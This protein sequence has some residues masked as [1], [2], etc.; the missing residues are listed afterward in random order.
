MNLPV[1]NPAGQLAL[2]DACA[3]P[4]DG[5]QRDEKLAPSAGRPFV[6]PAVVSAP[7]ISTLVD[8]TGLVIYFEIARR[9]LRL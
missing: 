5:R 4:G 3:R 6:D 9:V 8:G 7:L 1:A 2:Q